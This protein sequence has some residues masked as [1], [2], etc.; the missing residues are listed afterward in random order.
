[1]EHFLNALEWFY[2]SPPCAYMYESFASDLAISFAVTLG[3][4]ALMRFVVLDTSQDEDKRRHTRLGYILTTWIASYCSV[5]VSIWFYEEW[6][7]PLDVLFYRSSD[8]WA[9]RGLCMQLAY[10]FVDCYGMKKWYPLASDLQAWGHHIAFCGFMFSALYMECANIFLLFFV[11]ELPTAVLG[12]GRIWVSQ[13]RDLT[14]QVTFFLCR[15]TYHAYLIN[16]LY[17]TRDVS[18]MRSALLGSCLS[19]GLHCYWFFNVMKRMYFTKRVHGRTTSED[20]S[21]FRFFRG[22]KIQY[23]TKQK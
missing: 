11:V 6:G 9:E 8:R 18:P 15:I 3:V 12:I 5:V 7:Q 1:M 2:G 4:Y 20:A 23:K 21:E 16:T 10:F 22:Q 17:R 14:F 13:R 19:F